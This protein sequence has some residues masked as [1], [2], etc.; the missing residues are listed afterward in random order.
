M[1]RRK[2]KI[3][4][5]ED[6]WSQLFPGEK[7]EIAGT[8]LIIE[9]MDLKTLSSVL[10]KVGTVM[11]SFPKV[12]IGS[13]LAGKEN[14]SMLDF[15]SKIVEDVPEVLSDMS[16]L[17]QDDVLKLPLDIGVELFAKCLDV[18]LKAKESLLKNLKKLGEGMAQMT[19]EGPPMKKKADPLQAV[20]TKAAA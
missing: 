8:T 1:S 18:N 16:G 10:K 5:G 14:S 3:K 15:I 12:D 6:D 11:D 17:D 20:L 7:F 4:L 19:Q 13:A 2:K 9:P